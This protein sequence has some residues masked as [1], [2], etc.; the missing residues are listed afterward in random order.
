MKTEGAGRLR[1]RPLFLPGLPYPHSSVASPAISLPVQDGTLPLALLFLCPLLICVFPGAAHFIMCL[2]LSFS[3]S[4]CSTQADNYGSTATS[5]R[6]CVIF[7]H[8]PCNWTSQLIPHWV[9]WQQGSRTNFAS[10]YS[11]E[12]QRSD[13]CFSGRDGSSQGYTRNPWVVCLPPNLFP[14]YANFLPGR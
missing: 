3:C 14:V 10:Y 5:I 1:V 6:Q 7:I 12:C 13:Q 9:S 11:S 8:Y 4:C 2:G